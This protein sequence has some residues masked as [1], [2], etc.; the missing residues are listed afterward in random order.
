[1]E[2]VNKKLALIINAVFSICYIYFIAFY[3]QGTKMQIQLSSKLTHFL[4]QSESG[5][6]P[7]AMFSLCLIVVAFLSFALHGIRFSKVT[8]VLCGLGFVP[9]LAPIV[10]NIFFGPIVDEKS[11]ILWLA[12][13]AILLIYLILFQIFFIRGYKRIGD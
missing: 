8:T 2:K 11:D 5:M 3:S 7:L 13:T 6:I 12:I 4:F 10:C 9:A 1:M